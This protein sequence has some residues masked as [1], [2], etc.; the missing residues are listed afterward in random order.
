M[1]TQHLF[2]R[3]FLKASGLALGVCFLP[4]GLARGNAP[5][6]KLNLA[7]VGCGG[8]DSWFVGNVATQFNRPLVYDPLAM[9]CVGD[10]EATAALRR[11]HRKGWEIS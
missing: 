8:R 6:D 1:N 5:S 9:E 4:R 2:R 11:T 10:D 7:L 3:D